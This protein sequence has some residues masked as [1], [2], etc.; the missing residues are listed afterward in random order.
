MAFPNDYSDVFCSGML[1]LHVCFPYGVFAD[2][3]PVHD[4][5]SIHPH[6][7]R[8]K[9][10]PS[11]GEMQHSLY[12]AGRPFPLIQTSVTARRLGSIPLS[13]QMSEF[14]LLHLLFRC[15]LGT[16]CLSIVGGTWEV[17]S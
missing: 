2:L 4:L 14:S 12:L 7:S 17:D 1:F 13:G 10:I 8:S 5:V 9:R 15:L 11:L 16:R 6:V 3:Y